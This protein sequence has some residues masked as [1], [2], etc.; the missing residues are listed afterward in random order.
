MNEDQLFELLE[1]VND[2]P[3][4]MAFVGALAADREAAEKLERAEPVRYQL[5]GALGWQNGAISNYLGASLAYFEDSK[6][7]EGKK[8][9][10]W[11]DLAQFLYMGKIYE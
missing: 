9:P 4:F 3:S 8:Q 6:W 7:A 5:G 1:A 2:L 10:G 11:R